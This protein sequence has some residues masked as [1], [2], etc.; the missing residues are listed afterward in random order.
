MIVCSVSSSL[1]SI[2]MIAILLFLLLL[3]V[4]IFII[5]Y[6][7]TKKK[8]SRPTGKRIFSKKKKTLLFST[9]QMILYL[10]VL[11]NRDKKNSMF[12]LKK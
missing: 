1:S 10:F 7:G 3:F 12:N 4:C 11:K 9:T 8:N 5:E 2:F 6:R